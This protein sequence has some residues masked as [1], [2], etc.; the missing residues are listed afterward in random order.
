MI[1]DINIPFTT[2]S[3]TYVIVYPLPILLACVLDN[4]KYVACID[5]DDDNN[6]N[7]NITAN[8]MMLSICQAVL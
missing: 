4:S 5:E 3:A 6:N 8:H 1:T 2:G 7:N